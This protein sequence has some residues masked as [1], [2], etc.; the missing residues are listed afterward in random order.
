MACFKELLDVFG[1][2]FGDWFKFTGDLA[3]SVFT[4]DVVEGFGWDVVVEVGVGVL[5]TVGEEVCGD[6]CGDLLGTVCPRPNGAGVE[7]TNK[8]K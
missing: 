6:C 7:A 5:L 4:G 3:G 8:S 2:V 1:V